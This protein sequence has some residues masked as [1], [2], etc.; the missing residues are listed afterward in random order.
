MTIT[1][2]PGVSVGHWSDHEA[3][4]GC[5]VIVPPSPNVTAVEIRGGAPGT[6]EVAL[7]APGMAVEE[8]HA[9]LLT[10]GSAFGLAAADGVISELEAAGIGYPTMFGKV[11]IVPSVVM[12]DLGVGQSSVRPDA[13]SGRAAYRS[14]SSDPVVAGRVGAGTG[15]TVA[16]WRG[17]ETGR[18]AGLASV[19]LPCGEATVGVL[20][21]LNA[22]GDVVDLDG[23]PITGTG[24]DV[25]RTPDPDA[26]TPFANTTLAVV[27]TDASFSRSELGRLAIRCQDALAAVL[28]PSHT[29]YD[30]DAAFVVSCGS[31]PAD[32]DFAME[33]VFAATAQA[34]VQAAQV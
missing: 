24:P 10:G 3:M 27:A 19:S 22:V 32:L 31:V 20:V 7:L 34:I 33:V 16:K 18:P 26:H 17:P 25:S 6:R 30:G 5:T 21:V 13:E 28:R 11:P 14:R 23:T 29:R 12:Y 8:I 1:S 9:I 15:A 2:V 4:T